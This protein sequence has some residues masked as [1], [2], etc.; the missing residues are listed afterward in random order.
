[1]QCNN[2]KK[3]QKK[4]EQKLTFV[5]SVDVRV[6]Y[7]FLCIYSFEVY[8]NCGQTIFF[9]FSFSSFAT[10]TLLTFD[11]IYNSSY[12]IAIGF[13]VVVVVV[14]FGVMHFQSQECWS[15][16]DEIMSSMKLYKYSSRECV[17]T[18]AQVRKTK[19]NESSCRAVQIAHVSEQKQEMKNLKLSAES[20]IRFIHFDFLAIKWLFGHC[21]NHT[22]YMKVQNSV[23]NQN[24]KTTICSSDHLPLNIWNYALFMSLAHCCFNEC[25]HKCAYCYK[26]SNTIVLDALAEI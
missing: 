13:V 21:T 1:M 7:R 24:G 4:S 6:V 11:I 17:D 16:L 26:K 8:A 12:K 25:W 9:F 19:E 3:K 5:P 10:K 20:L 2:S 14:H 23:L 22:R 15:T 18:L